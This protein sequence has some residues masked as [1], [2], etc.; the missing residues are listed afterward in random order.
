MVVMKHAGV[1]VNDLHTLVEH[2]GKEKLIGPGTHYTPAG[3]EML[4]GAVTGSILRTLAGGRT[5]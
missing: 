1:P 2:A 4:A 3:Y 5:R